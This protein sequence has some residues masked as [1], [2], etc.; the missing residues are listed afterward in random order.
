MFGK[1]QSGREHWTQLRAARLPDDGDLLE[2]ARETAA[3]MICTYSVDP[4]DW[5]QPLL[6]A[7][8]FNRL[9]N[10]DFFE[11]PEHAFRPEAQPA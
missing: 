4:R 2:S 9:P 6:A 11:L 7:M 3:E 8:S 5:P 1:K 10:L